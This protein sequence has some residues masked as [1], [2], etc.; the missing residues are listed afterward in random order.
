MRALSITLCC[1][2]EKNNILKNILIT[3]W[4]SPVGELIIGSFEDELCLCDWRYRAKR[5]VIDRRIQDRLNA[6]YIE[7]TSPVINETVNQL[8]EYF[9]KRR[10]SFDVPI[11]LVGS[12]FQQSVWKELQQIKFGETESYFG[13]AKKNEKGKCN[14]SSGSCKRSKCNFNSCSLS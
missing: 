11:K 6:E 14:S 2:L 12:S 5:S 3:Y 13:L 1:V 4:N 7:G 8:K 10:T 9:Q